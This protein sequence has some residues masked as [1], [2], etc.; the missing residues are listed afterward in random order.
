MSRHMATVR[1]RCATA[2]GIRMTSARG[3]VFQTQSVKV[4]FFQTTSVRVFAF[5]MQHVLSTR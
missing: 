3:S 5:W 1:T 4:Y 2:I